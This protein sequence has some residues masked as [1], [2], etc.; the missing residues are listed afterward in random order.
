MSTKLK[1]GLVAVLLAIVVGVIVWT[2]RDTAQ[3]EPPAGTTA[4]DQVSA[5]RPAAPPEPAPEPVASATPVEIPAAPA[6]PR[7]RGR[8]ARTRHLRPRA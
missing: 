7:H 8:T 3:P 1:I 4:P 5:T 6:P 2:G